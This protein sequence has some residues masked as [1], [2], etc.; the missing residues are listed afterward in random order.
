MTTETAHIFTFSRNWSGGK[1]LCGTCHLNYDDGDHIH[2]AVLEPY[3]SY[4]CPKGGGIGHS[5]VWSG[6]QAVAELRSPTD[7]LCICGATLVKEDDEV[8]RLS[9]TMKDPHTGSWRPVERV[10]T[11]HSTHE[12]RD[13]LLTMPD[14]V[15]NVQLVRV[16]AI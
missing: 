12:Q 9:W 6:S 10:G 1:R 15:A 2:V 7:N 14:E 3:T 13:G 11:K 8:W 4:V 5:G 16:S